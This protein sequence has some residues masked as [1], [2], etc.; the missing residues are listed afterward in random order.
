MLIAALAVLA[1]LLGRL[2]SDRSFAGQWLLWI[3][4]PVMLLAVLL[5]LLGT[6]APGR[7][8][9]F[10]RLRLH[11][12]LLCVLAITVYFCFVEHHILRPGPP[13]VGVSISHWNMTHGRTQ[14]QRDDHIVQ[15]HR[16]LG[17]VTI[18]AEAW[19]LGR[20]QALRDSLPEDYLVINRGQFTIVTRLPVIEARTLV[21][22]ENFKAM[23]LMVDATETLEHDLVIYAVDLPSDPRTPRASLARAA[24]ALLDEA[25]APPPDVVVGDCNMTRNSAS[26]RVLFPGMRHAYGDGGHGYAASYHRAFPLYH[27]DHILLAD[28][29]RCARY[30]LIDPALGRHLAQRAWIVDDDAVNE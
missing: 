24:R 14:A 11:A 27:I 13:P 23:L 19:S 18:L 16:I 28:G 2:L 22:H 20:S 21:A 9:L 30:D 26:L 17:D 15:I 5:G 7:P 6:L 3:P 8:A 4:T 10:K 12:W 29:I 1:W 25:G